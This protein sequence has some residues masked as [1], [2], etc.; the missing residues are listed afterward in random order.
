MKCE[1]EA[2]STLKRSV[3]AYGGCS[4]SLNSSFHTGLPDLYIAFPGRIPI[5]VEA[6]FFKDLTPN[7]A[8]KIPYSKIQKWTLDELNVVQKG[9]AWGCMFIKSGR[10]YF[11]FFV[12]SDISFIDYKFGLLY[13]CAKYNKTLKIFELDK[14]LERCKI[15]YVDATTI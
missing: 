6:K 4:F 8:K 13:T 15:P 14:M 2:K 9:S 1:A 10:D 5:L 11:M 7:F 3:R 12:P